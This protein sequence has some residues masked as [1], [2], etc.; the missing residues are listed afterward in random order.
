MSSDLKDL[1]EQALQLPPEARAA[2]AS[3]LLDSLDEEVDPNA[4]AAWADEIKR[5]IEDVDS[6]RVT[7]IPW[8]EVY[9]ELIEIVNE[10]R[11]S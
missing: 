4:E 1:L 6:G 5:R 3:E 7:T 11:E 8:S 10:P 2:L 9:D